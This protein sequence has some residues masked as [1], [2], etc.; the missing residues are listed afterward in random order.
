VKY[1]VYYEDEVPGVFEPHQLVQFAKFSA[2]TLVCPA[3]APAAERS[4][5]RAGEFADIIAAM[6]AYDREPPPLPP[7]QA[8]AY[9][10]PA[11]ARGPEE[12][13]DA[14][15]HKIFRHVTELMKEL[16]NR[17]EEK[18]LSQ[19]LQRTLIELKGELQAARERVRFLDDRVSQ[20]PAFQEREK[21][22]QEVL[23][24]LGGE[25]RALADRLHERDR[26]ILDLEQKLQ[27][28]K[29]SEENALRSQAAALREQKRL[30]TEVEGLNRRLAHSEAGLAKSLAL[31]Q[32]LE[33]E[34]GQLV[35]LPAKPEVLPEIPKLKKE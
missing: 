21:R 24:Q 18:A 33:L 29:L 6:E 32:R 31:I 20:I 27:E 17:R 35:P 3:D 13:L 9:V 14:S 2:A 1:W 4:W 19:S 10:D 30:G 23:A 26:R 12:V 34:L 16:E 15:S 8:Q 22:S 7:P 11:A 28:A 25:L 5:K